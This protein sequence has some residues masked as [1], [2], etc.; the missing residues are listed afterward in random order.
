MSTLLSFPNVEDLQDAEGRS[1][2]MWAAQRGNYNALKAMLDKKVSLHLADK[3]GAT[4]KPLLL[5]YS[6]LVYKV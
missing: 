4:G 1:A 2:L 5:Y 3:S 6:V